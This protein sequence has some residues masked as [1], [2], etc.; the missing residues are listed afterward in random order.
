MAISKHENP[1]KKMRMITVSL[2]EALYERARET[3]ETSSLSL[4]EALT[5][6]IALSLP[7][8]ENDLP[9]NLRS[10][11]ASLALFSDADLRH[12][13]DSKMDDEQQ[14]LLERLVELR[15][16]RPLTEAEQA[17]LDESL[18][19]AHAIMLHKAEAYRLLARRG[20]RIFPSS[21]MISD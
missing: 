6:F 20:H 1:P 4:E 14:N 7:P 12:L 19:K 13:A 11:L 8:F 10:E 21:A 18:N 5:Q 9:S 3:A 17:M 15:K 2:P 16:Q